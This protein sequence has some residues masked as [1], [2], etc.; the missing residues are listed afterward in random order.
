MDLRLKPLDAFLNL[1]TG[2]SYHVERFDSEKFR[3]RL[4]ET[5]KANDFDIIQLETLFMCPYI[6]VVRKYT[7][8]KIVLR[9]H[10]IEHLIWQRISAETKNPVK[11]WYLSHLAR[12]LKNYEQKTVAE[13][14]GIL[15]ISPG[16]AEYFESIMRNRKS[17]I[18][19]RKW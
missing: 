6:P 2:K 12:T 17:K 10:N 15:A 16:D 9:A 1:F 13:V 19:N 18:E 11:K 3:N 5:L 14:D 8:A 7:R 4:I